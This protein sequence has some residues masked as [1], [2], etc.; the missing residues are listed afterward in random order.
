MATQPMLDPDTERMIDDRLTRGRFA[1]R[2]DVLGHGVQLVSDED[3][4][5]DEPLSGQEI[6]G[7]ERGLADVAAGRAISAAVVRAELER[8]HAAR[9]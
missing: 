3:R 4:A 5:A 8:R 6:A 7:I 2:A 1:E 9:L